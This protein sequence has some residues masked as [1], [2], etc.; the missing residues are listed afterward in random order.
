MKSII[1]LLLFLYSNSFFCQK[2]KNY[3]L[4]LG[5]QY[6]TNGY[7]LSTSFFINKNVVTV[8]I[9][10]YKHHKELKIKNSFSNLESS[11]FIFGKINSNYFLKL[12]FGKDI[13]IY[14]NLQSLVIKKIGYQYSSGFIL[15]IIKPYGIYYYNE[16]FENYKESMIYT[17][18]T[19]NNF[20]SKNKII[21]TQEWWKNWNKSKLNLGITINAK[22]YTEMFYLYNTVNRLNLGMECALFVNEI[23]Q[24]IGQKNY[25]F[26]YFGF[27]G[28]EIILNSRKPNLK[29]KG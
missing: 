14:N 27:L 2:Q 18:T 29:N 13:S 11:P 17:N 26:Q 3:N 16:N 22:I 4:G 28:Y 9:S 7:S 25:N 6:N 10:E 23:E 24:L 21:G 8:E 15:N 1:Y 20:L 19:H 5:L 12:K